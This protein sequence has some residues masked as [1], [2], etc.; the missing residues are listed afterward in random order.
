[1]DRGE[2]RR[3][4][5]EVE[6][7]ERRIQRRFIAPTMIFFAAFGFAYVATGAF[8]AWWGK[9]AIAVVFLVFGLS[10]HKLKGVSWSWRQNLKLWGTLL[11]GFYWI[12][13]CLA[14]FVNWNPHDLEYGRILG[15][16][17]AATPF[18][19]LA[20]TFRP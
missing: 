1:M 19:V 20:R 11:V 4:L 15:G 8:D 16:V 6:H 10:A 5:E 17:L 18:L 12:I 13:A 7:R 3:R 9:L 2:A 14:Y